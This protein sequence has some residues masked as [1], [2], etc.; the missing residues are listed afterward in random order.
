MALPVPGSPA[1][2][3]AVYR[4][5][6]I[7]ALEG[8]NPRVL[9]AFWLFGLINN[10]L[11]VIILTSALDLIGPLPKALILLPD[12]LPGFLC[13]LIAPYFIHHFPYSLRVLI[14]VSLSSTGMLLIAVSPP[15]HNPVSIA[16]KLLGIMMASLSSGGGE[17]TF[18]ALTH[19]YGKGSLAMWSSGTGG[20]G[21][22]GAGAYALATVTIGMSSRTALL[23]FATLPAVM[24]VSFF[25]I[26]PRDALETSSDLRQ[27]LDSG[28]DESTEEQEA[29]LPSHSP[30]HD[31]DD[32]HGIS[33]IDISTALTA[34]ASSIT[35]LTSK[36]LHWTATLHSHLQRARSLFLPYMLPLLLVYISEYTINTALFPVLLFPPHSPR[37]PF[38]HLRSHYPTYSTLYQTGVFLSRSSLP[39]LRIR[40]LYAPTALQ[41]LN[42]LVLL[43]HAL[44]D[45][46]PSF[47]YVA[48]IVF[49]EGLLGGL[50]YVST[51][52]RIAEE[53]PRG[54]REFSLAA[55][56]V[57]DSGGILVS[58]LV[59]M[60]LEVAVCEWQVSQGRRWCR[61]VKPA[62]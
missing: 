38:T 24:F 59:S 13:K 26:L 61:M 58:A 48:P 45:F 34:S 53:V 11:Y 47:W 3:W 16:V 7:T 25:L 17:L 19:F 6:L 54:E 31:D 1:A 9:I 29:F 18:L 49:W 39:F 35:P 14:C 50:V 56:S 30:S 23:V 42:F 52:A 46:L 2:S 28:Q 40:S 32:E 51:F 22:V 8:Q 44:Y 60:V 43:L 57:S 12:I 27:R 15:S 36:P 4:Q 33:Q 37:T 62:G 21:I 10:V 20:A 55:T 5:K 41:S